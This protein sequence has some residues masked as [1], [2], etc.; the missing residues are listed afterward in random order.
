MSVVVVLNVSVILYEPVLALVV[1]I[2]IAVGLACNVT[3]LT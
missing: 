1:M 2:F 3:W